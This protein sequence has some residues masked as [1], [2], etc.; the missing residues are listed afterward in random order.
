MQEP[1]AWMTWVTF[2]CLRTSLCGWNKV[3][4]GMRSGG[5]EQDMQGHA[6]QGRRIGCKV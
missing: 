6:G 4:R 3:S 1:Q 2:L 5:D